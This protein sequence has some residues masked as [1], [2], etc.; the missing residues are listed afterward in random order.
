M[1]PTLREGESVGE[2]KGRHDGGEEQSSELPQ[3]T[4]LAGLM[5][6]AKG[7][8]T[9]GWQGVWGNPER[10]DGGA[11][12]QEPQFLLGPPPDMSLIPG[13]G[14]PALHAVPTPTPQGRGPGKEGDGPIA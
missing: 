13:E 7:I 6:K 12:P 5:F 11:G 3:A 9:E 4:V 1:L 8:R 2:T 14:G 10:R